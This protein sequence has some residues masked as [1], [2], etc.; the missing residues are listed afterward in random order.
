MALTFDMNALDGSSLGLRFAIFDLDHEGGA[1][2]FSHVR[3]YFRH[4]HDCAMK[5]VAF[6]FDSLLLWFTKAPY[7]FE[8]VIVSHSLMQFQSS[9]L[10]TTM[11]VHSPAMT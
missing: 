10:F 1:F 3:R 9:K 4:I 11:E 2:S 6:K 5:R 8:H 7:T